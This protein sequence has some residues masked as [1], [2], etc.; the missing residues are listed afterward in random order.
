MECTIPR[1]VVNVLKDLTVKG[2]LFATHPE[3]GAA[4]AVT[5]IAQNGQIQLNAF[6]G[7]E[8]TE[9]DYE[10]HEGDGRFALP[11]YTDVLQALVALRLVFVWF[12]ASDAP[13]VLKVEK[14]GRVLVLTCEKNLISS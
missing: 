7:R 5:H 12:G 3:T 13:D 4:V 10:G 1:A 6:L 11:Y 14:K 2:L 8:A 9:Q